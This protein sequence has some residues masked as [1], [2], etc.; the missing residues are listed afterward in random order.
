MKPTY[1]Q[2]GLATVHNCDFR[3]DPRYIKSFQEGFKLGGWGS[4]VAVWRIHV[5]LWAASVASRLEGDFVECGVHFGGV[6][7]AVMEFINFSKLNK[8]FFLLD[9]YEGKALDDLTDAE[10]QQMNSVLDEGLTDSQKYFLTGR[11]PS[12]YDRVVKTFEPF[13]DKVHVIRGTVPHT[14]D[15]VTSDKV[16]YLAVD[17]NCAAPEVAALEFFWPK[18]IKGGIVVLDDHGWPN[19]EGQTNAHA[20]FA[21]RYNT[22][23]LP[24]PTGQGLLIKH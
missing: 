1:F 3:N 2:D 21:K 23:V 17:M 11:Y 4:G 6:S 8:H 20:A 22:C 19:C 24:L 16:A 10:K 5:A 7:R 14:L 15:Q 12:S 18:L 13:G 9:T